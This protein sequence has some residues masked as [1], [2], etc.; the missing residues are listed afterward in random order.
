MF[1]KV[2]KKVS[3]VKTK[4]A[5][6]RVTQKFKQKVCIY[7]IYRVSICFVKPS[8]GIFRLKIFDD[9]SEHNRVFLVIRKKICGKDDRD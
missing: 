6:R 1:L 4:V 3:Y 5:K 9:F 7:F 8:Q 2:K